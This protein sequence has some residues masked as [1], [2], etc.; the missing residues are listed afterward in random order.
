MQ[1]ERSRFK[2]L[3]P[4]IFYESLT[5]PITNSSRRFFTSLITLAQI[6]NGN[7]EP[8]NPFETPNLGKLLSNPTQTTTTSRF[9]KVTSH[10]SVSVLPVLP[11]NS[12][13]ASK[14]ANLRA[15]FAVP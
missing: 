8:V 4:A 5:S 1:P 12:T 14:P 2:A 7:P 11:A 6:R 15:D 3:R 9:V 10:K 13:L